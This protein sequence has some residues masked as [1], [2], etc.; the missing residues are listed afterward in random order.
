MLANKNIHWDYTYDTIVL[1]FGGA[2]ATAAR[3][4]ADAGAEVLLVDAAPKGHE[5][6]NTRYSAQIVGS[7]DDF[8]NMKK[9]YQ[10]LTAPFQL[11]EE[12]IDTFVEGMV[13]M[14]DYFKKYLE[15][16]PVSFKNDL[17]SVSISKD[18]VYEY[19]EFPGVKAYDGLA[20]HKGSFD[21]ALWRTLRQ[22]IVDRTD[23]IDV[24]LSSPA[25]HLIQD[26]VSHT[27]LGV[28]IER[29]H[30]VMNIRALN[31]VVL[32]VGG[33]ENNKRAI[34][35]YL[36]IPHLA[37]LGTLFNK[38]DGIRMALEV[39][40]D[41]WHMTSYES[42]GI[43]SGMALAVPEGQRARLVI[44]W[45]KLAQ[46]SIMTVADDGSRFFKEDEPNRHGHLYDH[47]TWRV[48]RTNTHP[49]IV[50]DQ[51]QYNE[52]KKLKK[53]PFA[54]FLEKAIKADSIV[55]LAKLIQGNPDIL[56]HTLTDFNMFAKTG[57]DYAYHREPESMR[58][59]DDGPYYAVTLTNDILNTQGGPRRNS[60]A[61][62][63]DTNGQPIPHLY[64]AGELGGICA[65]Q[66]QGGGNLAEC[67]IFGKIAGQNAARPKKAILS[68]HQ[69]VDEVTSASKQS[70]AAKAPSDFNN[71]QKKPKIHLGAHQFLG[72]S[73]TGI[74][75]KVVARITYTDGQLQNVEIVRQS[76]SA[77]IG[78]KAIAELPQKMIAANSYDVDAIS[79]AS[80]SSKAIKSAVKNALENAKRTAKSK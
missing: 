40:A 6:G 1:G 39:G 74:G 51:T 19:P 30:V 21:A 23:K 53:L 49:H 77:D 20:V 27:I 10:S 14:R 78:G 45:P 80:V 38:G 26:P 50:F 16:D 73:D 48:P 68:N 15:V 70:K 54:N 17:E 52:F 24:W 62:V 71:N 22:K 37:P 29:E 69:D 11:D 58:P 65:N 8:D 41:L 35:D 56:T 42:L 5:G 47:G 59:F 75:G 55:N 25:K 36:G 4:A 9:Y 46:G 3:F 79:G 61:E 13:N 2:G 28:Q 66:Y 57:H 43:L 18:A 32:T 34:Q 60:R 72:E 76:E 12:M 31:G 44:S 33:F 7:S 64:S 63:I 67:L